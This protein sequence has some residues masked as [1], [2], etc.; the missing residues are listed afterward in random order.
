MRLTKDYETNSFEMEFALQPETTV[1]NDYVLESILSFLDQHI[2]IS[3]ARYEEGRLI[4]SADYFQDLEGKSTSLEVKEEE[5]Y[6]PAEGVSVFE[7]SKV[8]FNINVDEYALRAYNNL[9]LLNYSP[10]TY[11]EANRAKTFAQVLMGVGFFSA[12]IMVFVKRS[13]ST[14]VILTNAQVIF[15]GLTC[16]DGLH[17]ITNTLM[18]LR[19]LTGYNNQELFEGYELGNRRVRELGYDGSF[20]NNFNAMLFIELGFL[21]LSGV[22]FLAAQKK[23]DLRGMYKRCQKI[24]LL[25]VLF[26]CASLF[27]SLTLERLLNF[28]NVCFTCVAVAVVVGQLAHVLK[29]TQSYYGMVE[30][31]DFK[32]RKGRLVKP[33]LLGWVIGRMGLIFCVGL[34]LHDT[35]KSCIGALSLQSFLAIF[36]CIGRPFIK[37]V[38][39]AFV[40]LGEFMSL[41]AFITIYV[42]ESAALDEAIEGWILLGLVGVVC[43]LL[44]ADATANIYF[45]CGQSKVVPEKDTKVANES[46]ENLNVKKEGPI[47]LENYF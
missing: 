27:Y 29:H 2:S 20:A 5:R 41:F 47:D 15:Y 10:S 30:T 39:N 17:P 19:P 46:I 33:F 13:L 26:C 34:I 4:I 8:P 42:F 28:V 24:A 9:D 12:F 44:L 3:Q 7:S 32:G 25:V 18:A 14:L 21:A 40:I 1:Y 23:P 22:L 11:E 45:D 38:T 36:L 31:L 37:A 16:I 43:G 35:R 6:S